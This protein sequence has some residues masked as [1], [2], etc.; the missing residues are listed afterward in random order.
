[1]PNNSISLNFTNNEGYSL[2]TTRQGFDWHAPRRTMV[3]SCYQYD[4]YIDTISAIGSQININIPR[5]VPNNPI[6]PVCRKRDLVG[7]STVRFRMRVQRPFVQGRRAS[8]RA[9]RRAPKG[10]KMEVEAYSQHGQHGQHTEAFPLAVQFQRRTW[11]A[12]RR[13]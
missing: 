10:D 8:R 7:F 3:A 9:S 6:W 2:I 13:C 5:L 4:L 12:T 11:N 1:M